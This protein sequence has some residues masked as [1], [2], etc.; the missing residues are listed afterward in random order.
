[1]RVEKGAKL[2][3]CVLMQDTVIGPGAQLYCVI[4]D[5]DC[6]VTENCFLSG[7]ERLPLVIPKGER[8]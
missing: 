6:Q 5:K 2:K 3:N 4:A 8:V 1:M 7:S